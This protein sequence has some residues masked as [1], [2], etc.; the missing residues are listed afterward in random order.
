MSNKENTYSQN[1]SFSTEKRRLYIISILIHFYNDF[2]QYLYK[3]SL[4]K[5]AKITEDDSKQSI[6]TLL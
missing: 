1:F 5:I 3:I 6:I 4:T 2:S